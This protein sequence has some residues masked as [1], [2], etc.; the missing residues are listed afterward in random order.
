M[1]LLCAGVDSN[2]I[3]LIDRWRIDDMLHFLNVQVEPIK[4]NFSKLM[5]TYGNYSFLTKQEATCFFKKNL[6]HPFHW[7]LLPPFF[8]L[9]RGG[10]EP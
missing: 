6:T 9:E 1:E 7:L 10:S 8:P 3:N 4:S 5:L 2:I